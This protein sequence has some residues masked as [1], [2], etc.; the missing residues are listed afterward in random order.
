VV[1]LA[2]SIFADFKDQAVERSAYPADRAI[3]LGVVGPAID[4]V[5]RLEERLNFLKADAS[6]RDRSEPL[7]LLGIDAEAPIV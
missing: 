1:E 4:D 5:L 2:I 7:A 3:L 6:L